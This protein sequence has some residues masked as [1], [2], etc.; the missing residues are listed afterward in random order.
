MRATLLTLALLGVLPWSS[1]AARE[2]AS[3]LGRGWPPA[4]GNYGTAVTTLLDGGAKPMLSLLTLPTRGVESGIA[5]VPGKSGSDWTVRFSRA[6][7]RVYS[8]VSQ[9]DRGAVQFRTEQTPETVEIP[10][11]AALAQR[12]VGSWT[13]ALTQLA[14]SGQTAP[15]TEG[16]V[17][18]F[19]VD[20]VRYS[21]TRPSC[22]VGELLLQQAALLIEASEGKE[23]KRDK[24]WT[25]IESSLDELQQTLAGTAG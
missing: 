18:S 20:G 24:R 4:V 21:G 9:T 1:A 17:L 10:I 6:D 25:Q 13:T 15:V 8:W 5:L 7:E 16:E 14:P 11:P 22:G 23:K 3:T 2:C 12:L 19:L